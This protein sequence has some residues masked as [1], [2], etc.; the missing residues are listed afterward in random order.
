M[1]G[2]L[3]KFSPEVQTCAEMRE[4]GILTDSVLV[5]GRGYIR[6]QSTLTRESLGEILSIS[7]MGQ[8]AW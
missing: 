3:G 8:V 5:I 4:I 6:P 2:K 7:G 1:H